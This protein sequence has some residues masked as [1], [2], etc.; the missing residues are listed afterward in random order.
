MRL[1]QLLDRTSLALRV[2]LAAQ[3]HSHPGRNPM[4]IGPSPNSTP[5]VQSFLYH[6]CLLL[7][8]HLPLSVPLVFN[9]LR[10][11]FC[12][13]AWRT[14]WA[15]SGVTS[16][17]QFPWSPCYCSTHVSVP[18]EHPEPS[19]SRSGTFQNA[20]AL[21]RTTVR[22]GLTSRSDPNC[23]PQGNLGIQLAA[24]MN[25]L[26]STCLPY[27]FPISCLAALNSTNPV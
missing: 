1:P 23:H 9:G 10:T 22:L 13:L 15:T 2:Q 7:T 25:P 24:D 19:G 17:I 4:G 18:W 26:G 3:V 21:D 6:G 20:A 8:T 16:L 12:G 27:S 11:F 5:P 14:Y